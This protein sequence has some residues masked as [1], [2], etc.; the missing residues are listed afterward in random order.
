[1]LISQMR[2]VAVLSAAQNASY[3]LSPIDFESQVANVFRSAGVTVAEASN[4]VGQRADRPDLAVWIDEIQKD[5]GRV[6]ISSRSAR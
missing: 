3:P 1:M 4:P 2:L 5:I 6:K